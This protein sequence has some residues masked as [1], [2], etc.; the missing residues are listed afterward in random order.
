MEMNGVRR[1]G[2]ARPDAAFEALRSVAELKS[3][4]GLRSEP[5][6]GGRG[7]SQRVSVLEAE[8]SL[9]D[10]LDPRSTS[11]AT[12]SAVAATWSLPRGRWQSE[13]WTFDFRGSLG[14]LLVEGM[15]ARQL[16]VG[17]Q[18]AV[19]LLGPGDVLRPW[20]EVDQ[21]ASHSLRES[22]IVPRQARLALLDRAFAVSI[23]PWPE[24]S[25]NIADRIA[26]RVGWMALF[27]AIQGLRRV[28]ER[29][30]AI[31][32]SYADRWGRVTP[33][34]VMLR[35]DL[36]HRLLAGVIG[37]RRP[38]VTTALKALEDCGTL[39]RRKDHT[40]LLHGERPAILA[41]LDAGLP[42]QL[43]AAEDTLSEYRSTSGRDVVDGVVS[44]RG[45]AA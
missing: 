15:I 20:A 25:A 36:T 32:W 28:D 3:A 1:W 13:P 12:R 26:A 45:Q 8:P 11:T 22:W 33:G 16:L 43:H 39:T 19:E 29:L 14:L 21:E 18:E 35:L 10:G 38:S 24:I 7:G 9:G 5:G 34:G 44:A 2:P 23:G 30:L 27:S 17:G 4:A 37:A 40:W 31:L 6:T 41:P 42:G